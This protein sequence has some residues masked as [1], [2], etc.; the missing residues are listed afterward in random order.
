MNMNR[1][2]SRRT[3]QITRARSQNRQGRRHRRRG[4][5][6]V[7][8]A[9]LMIV[10]IAMVAFTI[11][12]GYIQAK[13]AELQRTTDAAALAAVQDLLPDADGTQDLNAA[14]AT[15]LS[16]VRDN[17]SESGF[18]VSDADIQIGRFD[19]STIYSNVTLLDSGVLDAVRV[20]LRRDGSS[21]PLIP[22]F[23]ARIL[24]VNTASVTARATAVLQKAVRLPAGSG[25]LPFAVP[26]DEWDFVEAGDTWTVYGDGKITDSGGHPVPGNWGTVDIGAENNSTADLS[27]QIENGLRQ[28]DLDALYANDRISTSAYLDTSEPI[29]LNAD[30]GLSAGMKSAVAAVHGQTRVIPLYDMTGG[31]GGNNLEYRVVKWGVV[32]VVDSNFKGSKSSYVRVRKATLYDGTLMPNNDLQTNV[33]IEGAFT[34]PVLVE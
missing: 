1:T 31:K 24:G 15:V 9:F 16:Y 30:P 12:Y 19:T 18:L 22:L 21:N 10:F 29:W 13:Q 25:V 3:G 32:T 26:V 14:R 34:S 33:A 6:A 4:A 28:S 11:D 2:P 7:L 5:I 20:T 23:F 8:A 27:N 17:L